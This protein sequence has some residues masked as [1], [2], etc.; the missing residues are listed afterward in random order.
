MYTLESTVLIQSSL[1][2]IRMLMI[3]ISRSNLK[4]GQVGS[5]PRLL[6]QIIEKPCVHSRRHSFDPKF[7]KLCQIVNH[8]NVS[9]KLG[10]V[11][12]KT[13]SLGQI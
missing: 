5:K 2:F 9:S 7:I 13:R 10:Q 1:N 11:G 8:Y 6:D 4:L 12:S 3:I